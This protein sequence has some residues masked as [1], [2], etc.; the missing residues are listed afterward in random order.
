MFESS[1]EKAKASENSEIFAPKEKDFYRAVWRWHF[2]AGL[3]VVPFMVML[4]V[5][6]IIYLFKPQLDR[7][8]YRD[9]LI[10]ATAQNQTVSADEQLNAVREK[11]PAAVIKSFT[12]PVAAERSSQFDLAIADKRNLLVF[13]DPYTARVLGDYDADNNLQNYAL[14]LHGEL[15]IGKAG[16]YLIELAACWALVLMI[17]G[18]YLWFPRNGSGVWGTILP[19]LNWKN[20]RIFWRDLHSVTGVYGSLIVIFMIFTGLFWTGFWGESFAN[21]WSGFPKEKSAAS[22]NSSIPTGSLN[23]TSDKKVAWAVETLPMPES[24]HQAHRHDTFGSNQD[25]QNQTATIALDRVVA[26]ALANDV[27]PGYS[28]IFPRSETGVF[29][30]S[31]PLNDPL[32]QATIHV[33]RYT[34]K[35]LADVRWQDYAAVPKTVTFGIALHEGLYFGLPNQLLMLFAALTV[36][37]LAMSGTIMWWRRRPEKR[38]GAPSLPE[39]F[40]LWKTAVVII[41]ALGILFPFVGISLVAVLLFDHLILRQLPKLR[42]VIG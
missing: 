35:S 10:V 34:G 14:L 28:I 27:M 2:Y 4:S 40:P 26:V 30:I 11:Y 38:L 29:T 18:L 31:A 21:V 42:K 25:D 41:F 20:K 3:F 9:L 32:R 1:A 36:F 16:D 12:P 7:L 5:T 23:T 22:V 33:D 15:M 8:M 24:N 6:G 17:S 37:I 39:N 19:R 13:V